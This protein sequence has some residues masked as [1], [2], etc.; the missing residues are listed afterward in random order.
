[1]AART[2]AR[3]ALRRVHSPQSALARRW[4]RRAVSGTPEPTHISHNAVLPSLANTDNRV[5]LRWK[6]ANT[7][8]W[9]VRN[10]TMDYISDVKINIIGIDAWHPDGQWVSHAMFQ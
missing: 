5:F 9:T 4:C 8:N 7:G 3:L 2:A 1:M 10:E 6:Q